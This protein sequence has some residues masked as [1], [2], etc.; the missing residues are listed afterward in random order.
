[1]AYYTELLLLAGTR[2]DKRAEALAEIANPPFYTAKWLRTF[3][4]ILGMTENGS[5]QFRKSGHQVYTDFGEDEDGLVEGMEAPWED[6]EEIASWVAKYADAG[7]AIHFHSQQADGND[8]GYIFD[9]EGNM[10][11]MTL[12]PVTS[13]EHPIVLKPGV[14]PSVPLKSNKKN[15]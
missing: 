6:F 13:W 2:E 5:F 12:K 7:S 1:M 9:G 10:S 8:F 15:Q 4:S 3:I 14:L 11:F